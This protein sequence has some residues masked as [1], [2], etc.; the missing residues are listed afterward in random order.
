MGRDENKKNT[1]VFFGA[2]CL[3]VIGLIVYMLTSGFNKQ[4]N[5]ESESVV[6]KMPDGVAEDMPNSK[7]EAYLGRKNVSTDEYFEMLSASDAE[8]DIS[9]VSSDPG[10]LSQKGPS[11]SGQAL[12]GATAAERVFGSPPATSDSRTASVSRARRGSSSWQMSEEEKLEYDRKRA[13]MVRDVI[14]GNSEAEVDTVTASPKV[15]DF[16]AEEGSGII[17]SLDDEI[18]DGDITY[19][20][21]GSKRPFRCMFTKD[22]KIVNGQRVTVRLLEDYEGNGIRIPANSHISAICKIGERLELTVRS[23]EL[24]GKIIPLKLDAYDT[25]GIL[26][27]YCPE[28]VASRNAKKASNEAISSAGSTFGGLVGDIANTIIRTG[29]NIA[30]SANGEIAVNVISGYEFFL[31]KSDR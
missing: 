26:G 16:S 5:P 10:A 19:V 30:K 6:I 3:V 23:V 15:L 1:W 9:L 28:T 29:A 7:R 22:H 31:V 20:S 11:T 18:D 14:T 27:I 25:D 12:S 4:D 8:E 24:N 21:D 13:E 2:L 17:S